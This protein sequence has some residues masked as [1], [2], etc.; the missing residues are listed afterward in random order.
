[1]ANLQDQLQALVDPPEAPGFDATV[2][3]GSFSLVPRAPYLQTGL[4]GVHIRPDAAVLA[5]HAPRLDEP[6]PAPV[7]GEFN[8]LKAPPSLG[9]IFVEVTG[10]GGEIHHPTLDGF[11]A[12]NTAPGGFG[13]ASG[14]ISEATYKRHRDVYRQD[15]RFV[16]YREA[17]ARCLNAG[18]IDA[19][20]VSGGAVQIS[21]RGHS[22]RAEREMEPVLYQSTDMGNAKVFQKPS[23]KWTT[24]TSVMGLTGTEASLQ[25]TRPKTTN[26][27]VDGGTEII[28]PF[29]RQDV[30][31]IAFRLQISPTSGTGALV[32]VLTSTANSLD[33]A[34]ALGSQVENWF[35][36]PGTSGGFTSLDV[37]LDLTLASELLSFPN[38]I[39][40]NRGDPADTGI[41]Y[42]YPDMVII[43]VGDDELLSGTALTRFT[44]VTMSDVRINGVPAGDRFSP[45]E[46]V[47]DI[48]G[49]MGMRL[50]DL[51]PSGY[52]ILPYTI[53]D[54]G[55]YADPLDY[56]ALIMGWR[57]LIRDT[58]HRAL[59][60]FGPWSTRTWQLASP[61][62][63]L[64]V[65]GAE[66]YNAI[67]VPYRW[68]DGDTTASHRVRADPDP[69]DHRSYF[70]KLALDQP[71]M[72]S[73]NAEVLGQAV[74][75]QLGRVRHAAQASVGEI[76]GPN[77]HVSGHE[78]DAGDVLDARPRGGPGGLTIIEKRF[79]YDHVDIQCGFDASAGST[80][81]GLPVLDR[82]L[83]RRSKRLERRGR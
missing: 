17:N 67:R 1:M 55:T 71:A 72:N 69:L 54:G 13:P 70:G 33:T 77:G 12:V 42:V 18:R 34:P 63:R 24:E 65:T 4:D 80:L 47:L 46:L 58:G 38:A 27:E 19:P 44:Q 68:A 9:R 29:W 78:L 60:E 5:F 37:D 3:S 25:F 81:T 56:A 26:G 8:F 30:T 16:V 23:T 64:D 31:R 2:P 66:I 20:V 45:T 75:R 11:E 51:E 36:Q 10:P 76:L 39:G 49:R 79:G 14:R 57:W 62:A 28:L 50:T 61:W 59:M 32:R 48:A 83:A 40:D 7:L 43:H 73:E 41:G 21:S 22:I 6:A 52:N 74:L 15:A 53:D 82:L 35:A